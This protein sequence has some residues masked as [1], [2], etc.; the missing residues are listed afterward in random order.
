MQSK[1]V[2]PPPTMLNARMHQHRE[3]AVLN[4]TPT[5]W[6]HVRCG[7]AHSGGS[8]KHQQTICSLNPSPMHANLM[9]PTL[10]F[11]KDITLP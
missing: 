4:W 3:T 8:L 10:C 6:L 9:L 1:N 2:Q 5:G 7:L 11:Q